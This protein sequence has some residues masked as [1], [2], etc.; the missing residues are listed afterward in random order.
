MEFH[1]NK[2]SKSELKFTISFHFETFQ[3]VLDKGFCIRISRS[4]FP[5]ATFSFKMYTSMMN[6]LKG[7]PEMQLCRNIHL[8]VQVMQLEICPSNALM[9]SQ[10]FFLVSLVAVLT[11][12]RPT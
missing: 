11:W 12:R 1:L 4:T 7:L 6:Y 10:K 2:Y 5:N 8:R 3:V 9:P